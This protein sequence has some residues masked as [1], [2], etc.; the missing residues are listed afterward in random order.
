VRQLTDD[1]FVA[2]APDGVVIEF[3]GWL[4]KKYPRP[5]RATA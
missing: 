1:E 3:E 5:A 2:L 4:D